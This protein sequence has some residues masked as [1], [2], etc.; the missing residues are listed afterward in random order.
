MT[1]ELVARVRSF[2]RAVTERVGA[3]DEGFLGRG[4]PLGA[5]RLLWEIGPDGAEVRELRRRLG[6]DSGY[7]SRLLRALEG[8]GLIEVAASAD[9]GR[10]RRARL[11]RAGL[12]ERTELDRRADDLA[13]SMIAPLAA[14]QRERLAAAMAEVE[15]LLLASEITVAPEDPSAVDALWC[16]GQYFAELARRFDDGVRPG[17]EHPAWAR[18]TS[19]RPR[20]SCLWPATAA[21]RSAAAPCAS[22]APGPPSSS[23]CGSHRRRAAAVS[24]AASSTCSSATRRR[25]APRAVRLETNGSLSEAIALYRATG[26]REVEPFNDEPYAHHWFEK[27]LP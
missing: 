18:T 15:R 2:N 10:V 25:P 27:R 26:Y 6:I 24:A 12:A 17:A 21:A 13:V 22:T 7:A 11:T 16:I 9:D 8:E 23:A 1:S 3:L 19:P 5:A 14:G 20:A 4:R